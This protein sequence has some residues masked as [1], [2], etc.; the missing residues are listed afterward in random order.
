VEECLRLSEEVAEMVGEELKIPVYLYEKSAR[1]PDRVNLAHIRMGEYEGLA[2]KL[3]KPEWKPDFGPATFNAKAGATV[4]GVR[5]FLIAYNIN[6][7]RQPKFATDIALNKRERSFGRKDLTKVH[8]ENI[9]QYKTA[10]IP[11][12]LCS[13]NRYHAH[14]NQ[15]LSGSS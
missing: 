2:E 9:L 11:V 5:E 8:K 6:L 3:K 12:A 15:T 4:I 7:I 1:S 13:G 10:G 14:L